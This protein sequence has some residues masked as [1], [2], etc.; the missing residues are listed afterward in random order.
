MQIEIINCNNILFKGNIISII[1]PGLNGYFQ[2]LENHA[3]FIS[4]LGD[5]IIKLFLKNFEKK[6][7]I[8]GGFLKVKKNS[9]IVI[10]Q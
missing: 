1:A 10:L 6:I 4:V 9:V 7:K 5:G 3:P 2:V 8:K